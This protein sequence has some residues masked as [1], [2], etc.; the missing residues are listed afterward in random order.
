MATAYHGLRFCE[1]KEKKYKIFNCNKYDLNRK[2][3][4]TIKSIIENGL[5]DGVNQPFEKEKNAFLLSKDEY[6]LCGEGIYLSFEIEE[7]KKYTIPIS[8]YRFVLMCKV[9][10]LKIRESEIFKGEFVADGNYVKPY[11]ILAKKDE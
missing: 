2:L 9:C 1:T 4:L 7:A 10:P 3:E 8:G 5:K 6:K 11:R